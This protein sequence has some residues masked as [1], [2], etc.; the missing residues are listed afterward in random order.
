[1]G[2]PG[3]LDHDTGHHAVGRRRGGRSLPSSLLRPTADQLSGRTSRTRRQLY[4]VTNMQPSAPD[5]QTAAV[6]VSVTTDGLSGTLG[7]RVCRL[8]TG[9]ACDL[10]AAA[11]VAFR[12]D[13]KQTGA[14]CAES[15]TRTCVAIMLAYWDALVRFR[16][17][18]QLPRRLGADRVRLRTDSESRRIEAAMPAAP[19]L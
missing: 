7:G 19:R 3:G 6:S 18:A 15:Q 8:R 10:W 14:N 17:R 13:G 9:R 16:G 4:G 11:V 2:G 12:L 5:T 1:M